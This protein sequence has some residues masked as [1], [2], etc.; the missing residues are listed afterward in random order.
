MA[1]NVK[2]CKVIH[3]GRKNP[4]HRY[5]MDGNEILE[6]EE[7]KDLGVLIENTMKPTKQCAAAAKAA[8]FALGQLQ[9]AFHYRKKE[10]VIPLYKTFIRPKLEFAAAARCP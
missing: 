8:N 5:F 7:E 4:G 3:F 10:Y 1:F 2:K 6:A 9:R